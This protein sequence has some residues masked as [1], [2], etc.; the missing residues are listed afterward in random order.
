MTFRGEVVC[1]HDGGEQRR[2]GPTGNR[3]QVGFRWIEEAPF[4]RN[5]RWLQSGWAP[6][7][8]AAGNL[9]V[10]PRSVLALRSRLRLRRPR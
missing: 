1:V 4:G 10:W 7:Y 9:A 8:W 2:Y 6:G 3:H 5:K